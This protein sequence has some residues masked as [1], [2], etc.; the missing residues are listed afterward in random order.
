MFCTNHLLMDPSH[1]QRVLV[2]P[3]PTLE[4][5]ALGCSDG[6]WVQQSS[7]GIWVQRRPPEAWTFSSQAERRLSSK[8]GSEI[9][10]LDSFCVI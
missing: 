10:V 9:S 7:N 2:G 5:C 6:I 1:L 8:C 3:E 4:S